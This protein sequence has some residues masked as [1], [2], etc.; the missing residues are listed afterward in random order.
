MTTYKKAGMM[1]KMRQDQRSTS[2]P[3]PPA[4][5]SSAPSQPP[6]TV[7]QHLPPPPA[8]SSS[9]PSQP[10]PTVS[11]HLPPPPASSSVPS[12]PPPTVNLH[13]PPTPASTSAPMHPPLPPPHTSAPKHPSRAVQ[14]QPS[15]SSTRLSSPPPLTVVQ[16]QPSTSSPAA[17][18]DKV[19]SSYDV[20]QE[21]LKDNS[22]TAAIDK[23]QLIISVDD[24]RRV[25]D[26]AACTV[27]YAPLTLS[28]KTDCLSSKLTVTCTSCDTGV[29][30]RDETA[31]TS[32][33]KNTK[34]LENNV[35]GVFEAVNNNIGITGLNRIISTFGFDTFSQGKFTRH[36]HFLYKRMDKQ[37]PVRMKDVI[38]AVFTHYESYDI[39]PEQTTGLLDITVSYDGTW[40]TRGH[41]SHIGV[42]FVVEV[43]TGF[44]IDRKVISNFCQVCS[45]REKRQLPATPEWMARHASSCNKNYT[46]TSA[47]MG[48]EAAR[49]LWSRST[50]LG[51]RYTT[52]VGDGDSSTYQAVQ[53]LNPYDVPVRKEE[54]V[55]H[56]SK[57]LGT[58]LRKLKKEM[59]TTITTKTG[60]EMRRS[61]LSG[62]SQLTEN[63]INKMT[64]Y[65]GKAV[66]GEKDKPYTS[67]EDMRKSIL[68][69][70]HHAVS[71]DD[72]PQHNYCPPGINSWC[73]FRRGE[74]DRTK[75]CRKHST[76]PGYFSKIP[77][78]HRGAILKVYTDLTNEDLLKRCMKGR[79]QNSNESLHSKLWMKVAKHK[80]AGISRVNFITQ[81]VILEHNFGFE[82]AYFPR[83]L[84][85]KTTACKSA[86]LQF[87]QKESIRSST[88]KKTVRCQRKKSGNSADYI[89]GG[90]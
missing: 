32:T 72:R 29:V 55:N 71:T 25:L 74:A 75:F 20:R 14:P 57:R 79:T 53:Q 69:S 46:G 52:Y 22:P 21:L 17:L 23:K 63:T 11:L 73:F 27:C 42:G 36:A 83:H 5:S 88:P 86:N 68:A 64:S 30:I 58:R 4:S 61:L 12:Q 82:A 33:G 9:A 81:V 45:S 90:F 8:S 70:Y 87:L 7:S 39:L 16:P 51:L 18:V 77:S 56:V 78:E 80:F 48:T 41:S 84:G 28:A 89:S 40:M 6:P 44:I 10:P 26:I 65:F 67:T 19:K 15:T 3:P 47:S 59:M 31:K 60:K 35:K 37:Y 2:K 76:K 13:L 49:R 38:S 24:I 62:P 1:K 54:C 85:F 43:D 66:R 50:Q 34:M